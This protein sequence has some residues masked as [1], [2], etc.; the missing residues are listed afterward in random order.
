MSKRSLIHLLNETYQGLKGSLASLDHP[1]NYTYH[2]LFMHV[3]IL[4]HMKLSMPFMH[5]PYPIG[6]ERSDS[7]SKNFFLGADRKGFPVYDVDSATC[8]NSIQ[9]R[10]FDNIESNDYLDLG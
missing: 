3:S 4:A 5:L 7:F 2:G 6:I 9:M 1:F 8:S 10:L